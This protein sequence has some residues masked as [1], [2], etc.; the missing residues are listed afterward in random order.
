MW[1]VP[2]QGRR[3]RGHKLVDVIVGQQ[4]DC[5]IEGAGDANTLIRKTAMDVEVAMTSCAPLARSGCVPA[6]ASVARPLAGVALTQRALV[7]DVHE[8][9]GHR[10]DDLHAHEGGPLAEQLHEGAHDALLAEKP[11]GTSSET[12]AG[13]RAAGEGNGVTAGGTSVQ[14]LELGGGR[15]AKDAWRDAAGMRRVRFKRSSF[16]R[17]RVLAALNRQAVPDGATG[18]RLHTVR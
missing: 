6:A 12:E 16:A 10:L 3:S 4:V 2:Q 1:A 18:N 13:E 9:D 7:V 5:R 15:A 11:A 8:D 14:A 17:Q